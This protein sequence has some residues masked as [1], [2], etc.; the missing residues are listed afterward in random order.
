[1]NEPNQVSIT[2]T[3]ATGDPCASCPGGWLVVGSGHSNGGLHVRYLKCALC[4]AKPANN[5]V[6][7]KSNE[8]SRRRKRRKV[9][10]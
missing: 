4:G 9:L 3:P 7:V 6:I 1:M 8:V 2:A 5:K 10:T